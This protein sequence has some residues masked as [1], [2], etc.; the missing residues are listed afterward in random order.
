MLW[1]EIIYYCQGLS[2]IW[3]VDEEEVLFAC[4]M[5]LCL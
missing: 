1:R 5:M 4:R 3:L 2:C